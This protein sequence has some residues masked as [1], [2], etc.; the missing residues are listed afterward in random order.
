MA[1]V[2]AFRPTRSIRTGVH[3]Q[4][5]DGPQDR[6]FIKGDAITGD[7]DVCIVG[8]GASGAIAALHLAERGLKVHILEVGQNTDP[9]SDYPAARVAMAGAD[10]RSTATAPL[11]PD[12]ANPWTLS[13][14]GGGMTRFAG[15]FFRMR[16]RD[17]DRHQEELPGADLAPEWPIRYADLQPWYEQLERRF[18]IARSATGDT[19][20]PPSG[21]PILPPHESSP[22]AHLF[23]V[24]AG[25]RNIS[26]FPTPVAVNSRPYGGRPACSYGSV[27][28]EKLCRSG[29]RA[30]AVRELRSSPHSGN[31]RITS[32]AYVRRLLV[33]GD[34]TVGAEWVDLSTGALHATRARTF[35]LAAGAVQSAALLLRSPT[36][37]SPAGLG[38]ETDM[39]GRG[40]CLKRSG[41]VRA[42]MPAGASP[43]PSLF[44]TICTTDFYEQLP[45]G[46]RPGG[47]IYEAR[48][49]E[50]S[51]PDWRL[52]CVTG[53]TPLRS[54]RVQV[55]GVHRNGP[56]RGEP[57]IVMQYRPTPQDDLRL[58]ELLDVTA[59]TV[60]EAGGR[61]IRTTVSPNELGAAH[62]LGSCR[63]GNDP[64]S[65]V[66]DPGGRV[67]SSDNTYVV[68]GG[69]F[70]YA[71]AVNPTMTIMANALRIA[72][73]LRP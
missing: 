7:P 47:L 38:N 68:D 62:L 36:P 46:L 1:V 53:D 26:C 20:A 15:I 33:R 59:S 22:E 52:H 2:S 40:L 10:H 69:Y 18:G 61:D 58:G 37:S 39:V 55:E 67:H 73:L 23:E 24:A 21:P 48:L 30:D 71:T 6:S 51:T 49:S 13:A 44:S 9:P 11:V 5:G 64:G 54:N 60:R 42:Q 17:F 19:N 12:A 28:N 57:K 50:R 29:A 3:A 25:K 45:S 31:I 35:L 8:S 63:A 41:Y 27:C 16:E 34:T 66:V 43:G 65:S 4:P 14:V 56:L 72:A 32:Q 70:P